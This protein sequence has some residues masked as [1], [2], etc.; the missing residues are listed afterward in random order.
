MKKV[1]SNL[2][3][4]FEKIYKEIQEFSDKKLN[5]SR[6]RFICQYCIGLIQS[7][8]VHSSNIAS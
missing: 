6:R 2:Q 5:K 8:G 4:F 7:R 3:E 1:T